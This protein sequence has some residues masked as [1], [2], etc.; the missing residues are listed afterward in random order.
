[1]D[2]HDILLADVVVSGTVHRYEIVDVGAKG[3][4][5]NYARIE[6]RVADVYKGEVG[7]RMLA[8]TWDNS[9]FGEPE[10]FPRDK[11]FIFALRSSETPMLPLRGPSAT[12]LPTPE[13]DL[14]TIL[15][16]PCAGAF[17]FEQNGPVGRAIEMIFDGEGDQKT[18]INVL[19]EY[20]RMNGKG[21]IY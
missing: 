19:S 6:L 13:S 1:M 20:L 7:G 14:M 5:P 17:I 18:E 3:P 11:V 10:D 16:A 15:Q 9:T 4:L 21:G 2:F 8:I 12:V